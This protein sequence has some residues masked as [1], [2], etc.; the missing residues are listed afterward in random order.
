MT[1]P[2][3]CFPGIEP[4][5]PPWGFAGSAELCSPSGDREG[6]QSVG[7]CPF[8]GCHLYPSENLTFQVGGGERGQECVTVEVSPWEPGPEWG[9]LAG[10]CD[11]CGCWVPPERDARAAG[12]GQEVSDWA[13]PPSHWTIWRR[14]GS[15]EGTFV[16]LAAVSSGALA[17]PAPPRPPHRVLASFSGR[18]FNTGRRLPAIL[19]LIFPANQL[20]R[21]VP[22]SFPCNPCSHLSP[23]TGAVLLLHSESPGE[24]KKK[25]KSWH[26]IT[27]NHCLRGNHF[28][29]NEV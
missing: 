12:L 5:T 2:V 16:S 15:A 24:L 29:I 25:K 1:L 13:P 17:T 10:S 26:L 11:D 20:K 19:S 6:G 14:A 8:S 9:S 3:Y 22:H 7:V 4:E 27:W 28:Q 18:C 21:A 23:K